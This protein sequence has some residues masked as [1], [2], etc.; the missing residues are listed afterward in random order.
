MDKMVDKVINLPIDDIT[1]SEKEV[2]FYFKGTK[3]VLTF[4]A[5]GTDAWL[6]TNDDLL[7]SFIGYSITSLDFNEN[8][9]RDIPLENGSFIRYYDIIVSMNNIKMNIDLCLINN[10]GYVAIDFE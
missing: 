1:Y 9:Y 3:K 4:T 7:E 5:N 6:Y 2:E 10:D 8:R